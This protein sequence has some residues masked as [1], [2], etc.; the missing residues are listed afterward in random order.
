MVKAS[1]L[2]IRKVVMVRD[3]S[4]KPEDSWSGGAHDWWDQDSI[5]QALAR[6]PYLL[7]AGGSDLCGADR[8]TGTYGTPCLSYQW[9]YL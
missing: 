5:G 6:V 1:A 8:E 7:L 3:A 2:G 4:H 9:V